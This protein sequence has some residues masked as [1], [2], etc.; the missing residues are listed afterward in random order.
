MAGGQN[1]WSLVAEV[2]GCVDMVRQVSAW[3][4][5]KW[6][7][8]ALYFMSGLSKYDEEGGDR[9]AWLENHC[10][11]LLTNKLTQTCS[12]PF[13]SVASRAVIFPVAAMKI[14]RT[15]VEKQWPCKDDVSVAFYKRTSGFG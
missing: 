14:H 15:L 11:G 6:I 7:L 12:A 8:T 3:G 5:G 2:W 13:T 1:R 10:P 9:S 4:L